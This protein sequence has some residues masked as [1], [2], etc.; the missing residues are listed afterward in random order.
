MKKSRRHPTELRREYDF[1]KMK[2]GVRG[3]YARRVRD[4]S[5]LVVLDPEVA[6]AFPS[7]AAVNEALRGVLNTAKAVRRTGGLTEASLGSS[8]KRRRVQSK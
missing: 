4:G 2:G 1:A 7:A 8:G 3:K 6:S 5:N